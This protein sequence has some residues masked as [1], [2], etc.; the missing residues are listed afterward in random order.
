MIAGLESIENIFSKKKKRF[1]KIF[2][3]P[4]I[5]RSLQAQCRC[6]DPSVNVRNRSN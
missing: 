2:T 3:V 5:P 1:F 4:G 6:L